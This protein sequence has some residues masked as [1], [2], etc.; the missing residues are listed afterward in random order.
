MTEA[1]RDRRVLVTGATGFIGSWLVK[2]L[3]GEGASVVGL[4]F[5][6]DAH[7]ELYRSGDVRR[8]ATVA[9]RVEDYATVEHAMVAFE[10]DTVFHLAA[11]SI[12]PT[13][14]H[15]PLA[16]LETNVRGTYNV[17]EAA[18]AHGGIVRR[19]VVAS[20]DKA[21]GEQALPYTEDAPLLGKH[22][23]EVSK[24]CADLIAQS[25]AHTFGVPVAIARC[26]NVYGGG[27]LNWSRI[28]PGT[29]RSLLARERPVVRSDGTYVRDYVYVRDV[30]RAYI[31]LAEHVDQT[32]AGTSFN[33]ST[34]APLSVL[35]I[36]E[37]IREAVGDRD[38]EPDVR[39]TASGEIVAQHL[40]AARARDVLGWKPR[41]DL[42]SGLAETVPWYREL[43]AG[44]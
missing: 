26:G 41:Y 16:T 14:V 36:V 17:L 7:A 9:G 25:Y 40:S 30:A 10:T 27:D 35:Q 19:V 42:R 32:L 22:P 13:A 2:E 12:V 37:A 15:A 4:V 39:N 24:V 33:F 29:I 5:D 43:L 38:L 23:Y 20:S 11:Q 6:A 31:D 34:E 1:W 44:R 8:I 28:V 3:L 18:R 21:Y